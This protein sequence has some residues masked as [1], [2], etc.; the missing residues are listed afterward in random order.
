MAHKMELT[1]RF[2]LPTLSL[3][4]IRTSTCAS[5]ASC[6]ASSMSRL[7]FAARLSVIVILPACSLQW[8][9]LQRDIHFAISLANLPRL[10]FGASSDTFISFTEGSSWWR[11]MQHGSFSLQAQHRTL[12]LNV[13]YQA[14]FFPVHFLLLAIVFSLFSRYHCRPYAATLALVSGS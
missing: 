1:R 8:Q 12:D 14:F 4:R 9:F 11:S 2:E 13:A 10:H 7:L 3:P 5:S 6:I